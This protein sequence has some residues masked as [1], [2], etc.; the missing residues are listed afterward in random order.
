MTLTREMA[1]KLKEQ[2]DHRDEV[3]FID[4]TVR[5]EPKVKV[6]R[7]YSSPKH[8]VLELDQWEQRMGLEDWD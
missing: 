1:Q 3:M 7:P 2:M 8:E 5:E 4:G 6:C